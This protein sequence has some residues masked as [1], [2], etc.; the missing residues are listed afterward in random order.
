[1]KINIAS[2]GRFHVMDLAR[3]LDKLGHDV[4]FY[5]FVPDRRAEKFG[6]RKEC[7]ASLFVF[8]AP[9]L[10]LSKVFKGR[11][12]R[13]LSILV[14][15]YLTGIL[16]R[17]C[18]VFI[19]MSGNYVYALKKAKRKGAVIIIER[20]SKHI[21]EQKR[22]LES[23][24]S[25]KGKNPVSAFNVRRE[26]AGYELADYISIASEHVKRSFV[27]RN[28]PADKLFV[29][30]YGVDLSMFTYRPNHVSKP[31]DVLMVGCWCY[32]KG[33]DLIVKA[34]KQTSYT[35]L[36]VGSIGDLEFPEDKQFC[37]IPPVDQSK[38]TDY[39]SQA[40]VLI[41]PSRQDG[42]GMVLSQG[43][44]C[45]L[46]IIGSK[47]TGAED[48]KRLVEHPEYVTII[49]DYTPEALSEAIRIAL[50]K[51]KKLDSAS[52]AGSSIEKLSWAAYGERYQEMLQNIKTGG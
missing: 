47:D 14:Q 21:L 18:D 5:S 27:E 30:P 16:M 10:V 50:D 43:V 19:A 52:Y 4:R 33:C 24:S 23:I 28:Y 15:D 25:L 34:I 22:I 35:L 37:H 29:N 39:Y 6:L 51:Y 49:K 9:F 41:L 32:Q 2:P 42:F 3:E 26:L 36:H 11:F 8:M 45:N 44:A 31:Y 20:G 38:L 46:P 40:K 7:N 12:M 17:R 13:Q 48:L 1:M